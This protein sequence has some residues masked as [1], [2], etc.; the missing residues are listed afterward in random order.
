[1]IIYAV[2]NLDVMTPLSIT[3]ISF[4]KPDAAMFVRYLMLPQLQFR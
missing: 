1:M 3:G 2:Y 4:V